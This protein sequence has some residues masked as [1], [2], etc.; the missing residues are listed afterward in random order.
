MSD[1]EHSANDDLRDSDGKHK[2]RKKRRRELDMVS[3]QMCVFLDALL[4]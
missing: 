2:K 4:H 1:L 3:F